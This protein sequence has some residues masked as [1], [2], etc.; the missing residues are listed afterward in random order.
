MLPIPYPRCAL[1]LLCILTLSACAPSY[2][3]HPRSMA[4]WEE[5]SY[6]C[7][8]ENSY[9][10]QNGSSSARWD[11]DGGQA[12]SS[13]GTSLDYDQG[14]YESCMQARGYD[15]ISEQELKARQKEAAEK[16]AERKQAEEKRREAASEAFKDAFR[17]F[18]GR[19]LVDVAGH[20][21]ERQSSEDLLEELGATNRPYVN[22]SDQSLIW[23][24][25]ALQYQD[26]LDE[27]PTFAALFGPP[28]THEGLRP[29]T[30]SGWAHDLLGKEMGEVQEQMDRFAAVGLRCNDNRKKTVATVPIYGGV[31]KLR[32]ENTRGVR[33][34]PIG[35]FILH[36]EGRNHSSR[37]K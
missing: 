8:K 32:C 1:G 18:L 35:G 24:T 19:H 14:L 20:R 17:Y 27:R 23:T 3:V 34:V 11:D 10:S 13:A 7:K 28:L 15:L 9:L 22:E 36:V 31:P 26:G 4:S 2:W 5:D 33:G 21:A 37:R 30:V 6:R 12:D 16:E 29:I 25:V